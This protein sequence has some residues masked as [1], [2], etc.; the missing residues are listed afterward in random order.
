MI[1]NSAIYAKNKPI[2]AVI[3]VT[4][5]C[6]SKCIMC[7][8]W[9]EQPENELAANDFLKL[10]KT[11]KDINITGGEPFLRKDL[12]D[13]VYNLTLL[14]PDVRLV[15]SSN[16]FLTDRIVEYMKEIR[17]IN[18]K[19]CI[20][21][22]LDGLGDM[23]SK[24]RGIDNAFEKVTDTI[25]ALKA[26]GINDIRIGFTAG[27]DNVSHLAKVYDFSKSNDIEF[28]MS[29]V[30]N[31][32]GYFNIETNLT[33]DIDDLEWEMKSLISD[34]YKG[35]NP[36]KLFRNYY[37]NG[38]LDYVRTGKRPLPCFALK[39]S[40]FMD[41][42]GEVFPCNALNRSVGNIREKSF[43]EIWVS[44]KTDKMRNYCESCNSCWMV[45]TAKSS[46]RNHIPKVA[47]EVFPAKLKALVDV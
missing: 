1:V 7:N 9:K 43:E 8:I 6:N 32:E 38:I 15:F 25:K 3:A 41:S 47:A 27:K 20:G 5:K 11:L 36:R 16:G 12:V 42:F 22:S 24:I 44:D 33:P 34:G 40:F 37:I 23:H 28:T 14:N 18:K 4:Y 39:N 29:V 46:I 26:N 30:H 2:D 21:L 13:I 10:P 35:I 19:S 17:K 45:C 31:A